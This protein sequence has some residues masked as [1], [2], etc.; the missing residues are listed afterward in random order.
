MI[1]YL[2]GK[3]IF[4]GDDF[5]VIDAGGV[6]YKVIVSDELLKDLKQEAEIELFVQTF[7]KRDTLELYGFLNKQELEFFGFLEGLSGVGSKTALLLARFKSPSRLKK[8]IERLGEDFIKEVKGVGKKTAKRL[9]L[10]L[11]GKIKEIEKV[12]PSEK[13]EAREALF[14]LGFSNN[15]IQQAFNRIPSDINRTE[16]IISASLKILGQK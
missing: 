15:Q 9:L 5:V 13:K 7:L 16:E 14:S 4:K 2:K 12:V 11:T 10:E 6:G 8:E 3:I 1:S